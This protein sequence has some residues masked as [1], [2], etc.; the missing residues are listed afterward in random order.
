M[1]M[2]ALLSSEKEWVEEVFF[3]DESAHPS[4]GNVDYTREI[5][6]PL[7]AKLHISFDPRSSTDQKQVLSVKS[8]LTECQFSGAT[9][10]DPVEVEGGRIAIT[11][12]G[13]S[14][15][16]EWGYRMFVRP[17]FAE[18]SIE[19]DGRRYLGDLLKSNAPALVM[20]S[21]NADDE[22]IQL[23]A[24]RTLANMLFVEVKSASC[25]CC[26]SV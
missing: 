21:L 1:T 26:S 3:T 4:V 9:G 2:L 6:I 13:D 22:I 8:N 20:R 15:Q 12:M 14:D 18:T 19:F 24:S 7:A 25:F 11:F 5:S 17:V 10:W 16:T 23:M